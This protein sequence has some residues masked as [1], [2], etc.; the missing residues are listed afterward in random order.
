MTWINVEALSF[1]EWRLVSILGN[2]F[3]ECS[4]GSLANVQRILF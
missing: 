4:G 3:D 1:G 2:A